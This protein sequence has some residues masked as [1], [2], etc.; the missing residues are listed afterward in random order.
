M[1]TFLFGGHTKKGLHDL[2]GRKF[3]GKSF[4][5]TYRACLEKFKQKLVHPKFA[6]SYAYGVKR[7][8]CLMLYC[9]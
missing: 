9:T 3:A 1:K 2:C 6:C 4:T 5:E 8:S 7:F